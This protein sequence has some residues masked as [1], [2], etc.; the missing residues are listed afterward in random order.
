M[1]KRFLFESVCRAV[2]AVCIVAAIARALPAVQ[3][4]AADAALFDRIDA[5]RDGKVTA[6]EVPSDQK[7]LFERLLRRAEMS[8]DEALTRK[9]FLAALVPER[10][11]K[12]LEQKR[13]SEG[14]FADA[15]RWLLLSL[16][17]NPI[18]IKAAMELLGRDR[19]VLRLP[20]CR[21]ADGA[22]T[23][24]RRLL[25]AAGLLRGA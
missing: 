20:M 10:P 3:P 19:G 21:A 12:T 17:T 2:A 9:E 6:N 16:D 24:V 25:T 18:P 1:L 7:R 14:P 5:N 22:I 13:S 15:V 11:Q 8:S 4:A 23:E